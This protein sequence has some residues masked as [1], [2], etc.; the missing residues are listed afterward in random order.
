MGCAV[1]SVQG[2]GS[3][4][5]YHLFLRCFH[6]CIGSAGLEVFGSGRAVL[7]ETFGSCGPFFHAGMGP[8]FV[9]CCYCVLAVDC[10]PD[11]EKVVLSASVIAGAFGTFGSCVLFYRFEFG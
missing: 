2:V 9:S 5:Q 7:A 11:F 3:C 8:A 6:Y 4:H 1:S 10:L